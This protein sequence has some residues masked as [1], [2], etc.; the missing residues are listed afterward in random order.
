M[1]MLARAWHDLNAA[2]IGTEQYW[3]IALQNAVFY[4]D[5]E[6][7]VARFVR[8]RTLD[9]GAGR[10]A[11]RNLLTSHSDFYVSSDL[12]PVH[13][14]LDVIF[15]VTGPFPFADY[16]FDTVFCCSV[17][18]HVPEPWNALQ[19][20]WR[21]LRPK[22]VLILSVPF[23]FYLHGQPHDYYRFT[24]YG[25]AYLAK[26]AGFCIE[27]AVVSGGVG[28]L[29]FNLP[30]ILLSSAFA[31]VGLYRLIPPTT[32]FWKAMADGS[33]NFV[34]GKHLLAMNH[35]MVLRKATS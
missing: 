5:M 20:M 12:V 11:W 30:S 13:P 33:R 27:E 21:V 18:E 24:G 3:W 10:L 9:V 35:L 16:T 32:R 34:G 26:R 23:I 28:D 8:G 15:D 14:E 19:E 7:L 29:V 4:R 17:L 6:P 31:R 2:T 25:A 1:R 22:G